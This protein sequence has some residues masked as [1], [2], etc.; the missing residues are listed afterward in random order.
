[1]D[2]KILNLDVVVNSGVTQPELVNYDTLGLFK[3]KTTS[4]GLVS[5]CEYFEQF[6]GKDYINKLVDVSYSYTFNGVVYIASITRV[7][8]L[9]LHDEVGFEKTFLK[10]FMPW[11]IIDFG[12][13]KRTNILSTAKLFALGQIGIV[14]GYDLMNACASEVEQYISGPFQ[15]LIDKMNSLVGVKPYLTTELA[16]AINTIL[17]DL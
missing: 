17:T 12:I 8:W 3:K 6:D 9:N 1:M 11:E 4:K 14:N 2:L 13:T 16:A 7:Q 5:R 15:P 10:T